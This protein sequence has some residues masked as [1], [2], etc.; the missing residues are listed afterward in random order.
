MKVEFKRLGNANENMIRIDGVE[1]FYYGET[2]V[3]VDTFISENQWGTE[4][5][6]FLKKLQPDKKKRYLYSD[7]V[8]IMEERL[9]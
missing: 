5:E 1:L 8:K 6:K 2:L 3:G 4:G 9:K 7:V